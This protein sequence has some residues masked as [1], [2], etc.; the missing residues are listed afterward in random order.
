M[1]R[2]NINNDDE[3]NGHR[4]IEMTTFTYGTNN[5]GSSLTLQADSPNISD[6]P[7]EM[8]VLI[9]SYCTF[10]DAINVMSTSTDFNSFF[11]STYLQMLQHLS[12]DQPYCV[13]EWFNKHYDKLV[14][15]TCISGLCLATFASA[16]GTFVGTME[17]EEN[18]GIDIPTDIQYKVSSIYASLSLL[19]ASVLPVSLG[20]LNHFNNYCFP[21]P[22]TL[23]FKGLK[24]AYHSSI[25]SVAAPVYAALAGATTGFSMGSF[26]NLVAF[27]G[28]GSIS[29]SANLIGPY[30]L[31][32]LNPIAAYTFLGGLTVTTLTG[33]TMYGLFANKKHVKEMHAQREI[34]LVERKNRLIEMI[35]TPF[36]MKPN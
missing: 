29:V 19:G 7:S 3:G 22:M 33:V 11:N 12:I 15:N 2:S 24:Y 26:G 32:S 16:V 23:F 6:L 13:S 18:V 8:K 5:Q 14:K 30:A 9:L 34:N 21:D 4:K 35:H 25:S 27:I 17:G 28:G 1:H 10:Q 36:A 20:L 31:P